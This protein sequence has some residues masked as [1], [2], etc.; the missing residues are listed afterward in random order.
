MTGVRVMSELLLQ[1]G[2]ESLVHCHGTL[3]AEDCF[4]VLPCRRAGATAFLLEIG[5]ESA[6]GLMRGL[7]RISWRYAFPH[8]HIANELGY[9]GNEEVQT[10]CGRVAVKQV[11]EVSVG[12]KEILE[13]CSHVSGGIPCLCANV[14]ANRPSASSSSSVWLTMS[15]LNGTCS[16]FSRQAIRRE[17]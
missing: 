3:S 8:G 2:L 11:V 10:R 17:S 9:L 1:L 13:T 4:C 16:R 15:A 12:G 6:W 14:S 7:Q 5:V